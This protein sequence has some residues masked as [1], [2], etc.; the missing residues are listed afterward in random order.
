MISK[1]LHGYQLEFCGFMYGGARLHISSRVLLHR[2]NLAIEDGRSD[3]DFWL[4]ARQALAFGADSSV[5]VLDDAYSA[6]L[7]V[8]LWAEE[9]FK[10]KPHP[11]YPLPTIRD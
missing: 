5:E 8:L 9:K 1:V 6:A 3:P 11:G 10:I 7:G 2:F 4:S